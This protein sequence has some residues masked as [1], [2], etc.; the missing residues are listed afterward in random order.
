MKI[1]EIVIPCFNLEGMLTFYENV[2]NLSFQKIQIN[3]GSIFIGTI[4]TIQLTLC[5]AT[6]AGIEVKDNRHQLTFLV[7]DMLATIAKA[8]QYKGIILQKAERVE[9]FLQASIRDIDGN[10]IILKSF[11]T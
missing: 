1:T 2:F 9:R 8:T 10:S 4:D 5:P 7:D 11:I 6:I 3:K